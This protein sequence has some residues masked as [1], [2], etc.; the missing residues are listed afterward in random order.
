ME[1]GTAWSILV[2]SISGVFGAGAI[3]GRTNSK[4]NQN[5]KDIEAV[6]KDVDEVKQDTKDAIR[7]ISEQFNNLDGKIDRIYNHLLVVAGNLAALKK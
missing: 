6:A 5:A 4:I 7:E 3:V 2:G 1:L